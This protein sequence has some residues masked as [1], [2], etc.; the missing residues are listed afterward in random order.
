MEGFSRLSNYLGNVKAAIT[1][2]IVRTSVE[3]FLRL[4]ARGAQA[5]GNHR[6][7]SRRA[8]RLH[9]RALSCNWTKPRTL[10]QIE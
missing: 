9:A 6:R 2:K 4:P 8:V 7:F 10:R 3:K 5:C 1:S